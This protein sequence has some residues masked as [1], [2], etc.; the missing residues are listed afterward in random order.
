MGVRAP[1]MEAYLKLLCVSVLVA[2]PIIPM[3]KH[4]RGARRLKDGVSSE[5]LTLRLR[6]WASDLVPHRFEDLQQKIDDVEIQTDREIQRGTP[7][8]NS[9]GIELGKPI[10]IVEQK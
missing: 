1:V 6:F 2:H 9:P 4:F 7:V 5:L 8:I 3:I 10:E